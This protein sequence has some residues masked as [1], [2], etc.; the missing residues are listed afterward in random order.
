M[1]GAADEAMARVAPELRAA[2]ELFPKVDFGLGLDVWRQPILA[3]M[4]PPL[5]PELAA[6]ACE[7]R[8]IPGPEGAPDVRI[9]IYTPPKLGAAPGPALLNIHGGGYVIGSPEQNDPMN[10]ARAVALGCRVVATSYRLAPETPW[11]GAVQ[12]CYATL[13]WMHE[14][15]AELGI[16]P[17]RIAISGESAG[18]GHAAALAI[19]ARNLSRERGGGPTICFQLLDSPM[20]D[21]RT[22][23]TADPHPFCGEFTWKPE[24]NRFGWGG[25]LGVEPGG[26]VPEGS[27]PA[28]VNDLTGL[29]PACITVGALDLFLEE[30]LEYARRLTRAGV[31][32]ELHV[33]PG[34]YH[35]FGLARGAP[36]VEQKIALEDAALKRALGIGAG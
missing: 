4:M 16:D 23:S 24:H 17:D 36:L 34:G 7:Q 20:L 3:G 18:G 9:L 31:A 12:D 30:D 27:V 6:V 32:V 29:P 28:R 26:E 33:I 2:L 1:P 10:R 25:L 21:D 5:P 13:S 19:H 14:N 11:P 35:G 22:G 15:A 8:F